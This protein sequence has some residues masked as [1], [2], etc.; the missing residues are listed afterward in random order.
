MNESSRV[1]RT[2]RASFVAAAIAGAAAAA[3]GSEPAD[4]PVDASAD[5][6]A[7]AASDTASDAA[8]DTASDATTDPIECVGSP[9]MCT[10]GC[11]GDFFEMPDCLGGA[12]VCPPETIPI[13]ECPAG[14]CFGA[15]LPGEVCGDGWECRPWMNDALPT[16]GAAP[17]MLCADCRG[18]DGP[19]ETDDCVCT[20][21]DG[22][23]RCGAPE[24]C[25][26]GIA[27]T[28]FGVRLVVELERCAFT[29]AELEGGVPLTYRVEVDSDTPVWSRPLD[30]GGCDQPD[31]S[32]LRVL[33]RV[34]GGDQN[35][36]ICDSGLCMAP[37]PQFSVLDPGVFPAEIV[38]DGRNW[39][40]P[41][42]T[43]N[44]PGPPFP[45]G[46]YRFAVRAAGQYEDPSGVLLEWDIT[47]TA[48]VR[49]LE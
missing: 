3:C 2:L 36:C 25:E 14:S 29:A 35:W 48:P 22:F 5:T 26:V 12:W 1:A 41:S 18:F 20:C 31:A 11:G 10:Y 37:E 39:S 9:P 28:G 42:D 19:Y 23:V 49:V 13:D 43:G 21:A 40:G 7:D 32:G 30:A 45:P 27:E 46:E 17:E 34:T 38:W 4:E 24:T 16:C 44:P 15:P 33:E 47:A 8:L 6:T